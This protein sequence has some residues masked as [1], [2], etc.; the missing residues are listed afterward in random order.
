LLSE[1]GN[2]VA[3]SAAQGVGLEKLLLKVEEILQ[4]RMISV[5]VKLPYREA[6][7]VAMFHKHGSVEW[8]EYSE[9]GTTIRGFLPG[10][11]RD[12]FQGYLVGN[13]RKK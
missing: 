13:M 7:L 4:C 1:F 8:E 12:V 11:L 6:Q 10:R 3:V 5:K 2:R 9:E